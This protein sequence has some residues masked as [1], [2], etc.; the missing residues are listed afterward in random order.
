MK[1]TVRLEELRGWAGMLA[2]G[3]AWVVEGADEEGGW[4]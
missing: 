1:E 2:R 3:S 4:L